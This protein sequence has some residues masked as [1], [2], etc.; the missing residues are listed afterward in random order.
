MLECVKADPGA[1][2]SAAVL[3]EDAARECA[4]GAAQGLPDPWLELSARRCMV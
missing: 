3:H 2:P 4:Y 1:R